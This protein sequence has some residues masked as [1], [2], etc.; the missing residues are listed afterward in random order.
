MST[1]AARRVCVTAALSR[2]RTGSSACRSSSDHPA[3]RS[4][5][6]VSVAW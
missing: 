1:S 3:L 5:D 4:A 2:A 6:E